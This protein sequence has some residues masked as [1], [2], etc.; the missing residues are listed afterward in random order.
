MSV[1]ILYKNILLL[2]SLFILSFCKSNSN[3]KESLYAF[4]GTKLN[5]QLQIRNAPIKVKADG[6]VVKGNL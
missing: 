2:F 6:V 4:S 1:M 5:K 3:D